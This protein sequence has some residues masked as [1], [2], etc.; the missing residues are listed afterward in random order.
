MNVSLPDL[1]TKNACR[2]GLRQARSLIGVEGFFRK[3]FC[4]PWLG[5]C[6]A[7]R[8]LREPGPRSSQPMKH[9]TQEERYTIERMRKE[10]GMAECLGHDALR[11]SES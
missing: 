5:K 1:G 3:L 8:R 9:L 2:R 6:D 11:H 10:G 4:R 7:D